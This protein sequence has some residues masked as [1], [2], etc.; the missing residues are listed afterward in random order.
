MWATAIILAF[1]GSGLYIYWNLS[2][3]FT[4]DVI[5]N[6]KELPIPRNSAFPSLLICGRQNSSYF[7][8]TDVKLC[9]FDLQNCLLAATKQFVT[10][11][12]KRD[13]YWN[14]CLHINANKIN[15][16]NEKLF[17]SNK[18]GYKG[19][20]YLKIR[21]SYQVY[22]SVL[23]NNLKPIENDLNGIIK[24]DSRTYMTITK[25]ISETLPSPYGDCIENANEVDSYDSEYLRDTIADGYRYRQSNCFEICFQKLLM[26]S[27]S[28]HSESTSYLKSNECEGEFGK[29]F[30]EQA[31]CSRSCPVECSKV[32][33]TI[34]T[35]SF[36]FTASYVELYL[37]YE[38]LKYI[39]YRE[40]LKM[41]GANLV[42]NIG[43][44]MGLFMGLSLLSFVEI[45]H[46]I[47]DIYRQQQD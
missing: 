46:F 18:G 41:T 30:D 25:K 45:L 11:Y 6:Y 23:D 1:F 39:E 24:T 47:V 34:K 16:S 29:Y 22:Y 40:I 20:L 5:T 17:K 33:Y 37:F 36:E 38:E 31:N 12:E 4:F 10:I 15:D 43:G 42:A 21:R 3:Y 44:L 32:T 26:Q 2:D 8:A 14:Y 7:P 35:E 27:C 28:G 13:K 19:G 9:S